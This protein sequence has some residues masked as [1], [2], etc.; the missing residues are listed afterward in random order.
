MTMNYSIDPSAAA[1]L[2]A[3]KKQGIST[4]WDRYKA[5]QAP[6]QGFVNDTHAASTEFLDD[7][8]IAERFGQSR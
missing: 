1:M 2:S 5:M 4:V 7:L 8:V 3:A 6:L